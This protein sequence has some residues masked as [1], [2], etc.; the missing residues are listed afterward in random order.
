F[1]V[2]STSSQSERDFSSDYNSTSDSDDQSESEN[3]DDAQSDLSVNTLA[4]TSISLRDNRQT[5]TS[6]SGSLR[7]RAIDQ[8]HDSGDQRERSHSSHST[9]GQTDTLISD[10]IADDCQPASLNQKSTGQQIDA[11]N[12]A[13]IDDDSFVLE[14][15]IDTA[16]PVE[17]SEPSLTEQ[18]FLP[19]DNSLATTDSLWQPESDGDNY[20]AS[21]DSSINTFAI[22]PSSLLHQ[23]EPETNGSRRLPTSTVDQSYNSGDQRELPNLSL[24]HGAGDQT[25][26]LPSGTTEDNG[27][28]ANQTQLSSGQQAT[29]HDLTHFDDDSLPLEEDAN[30]RA[31]SLE[32]RE[33]SP[34]LEK[35]SAERQQSDISEDF[36]LPE[37]FEEP[38]INDDRDEEKLS[39]DEEL[40]VSSSGLPS[41]VVQTAPTTQTSLSIAPLDDTA[42]ETYRKAENDDLQTEK[43]RTVKRE[44]KVS[45]QT[46]LPLYKTPV[47]LRLGSSS[48]RADDSELT[49]KF[50]NKIASGKNKS[51]TAKKAEPESITRKAIPLSDAS[52][53]KGA[54]KSSAARLNQQLMLQK[55]PDETAISDIVEKEAKVDFQSTDTRTLSAPDQ[56]TGKRVPA[57]VSD[58]PTVLSE[59]SVTESRTPTALV[60]ASERQVAPIGHNINGLSPL[61]DGKALYFNIQATDIGSRLQL[62]LTP[63]TLGH[64]SIEQPAFFLKIEE[65]LIP[66]ATS[67]HSSSALAVPARTH[68]HLK[69]TILINW[70][71]PSSS[72]AITISRQVTL[73]VF[74]MLNAQLHKSG[75]CDLTID[76]NQLSALHLEK[77][78]A[79]EGISVPEI[80]HNR[81]ISALNHLNG[82]QEQ[83][84]IKTE[85]FHL[86]VEGDI[87]QATGDCHVGSS[88]EQEIAD[89]SILQIYPSNEASRVDRHT[90]K[91]FTDDANLAPIYWYKWMKNTTDKG[92]EDIR[93]SVRD[94]SRILRSY[95][96]KGAQ[97]AIH[98][99]ANYW[100]TP[101]EAMTEVAVLKDTTIAE[102]P[103]AFTPFTS[104]RAESEDISASHP[105]SLVPHS[106]AETLKEDQ[107]N[108]ATIGTEIKEASI[109]NEGSEIHLEDTPPIKTKVYVNESDSDQISDAGHSALL[110]ISLPRG[111]KQKK[112]RLQKIIPPQLRK[113]PKIELAIARAYDTSICY[114]LALCADKETKRKDIK[115]YDRDNNIKIDFIRRMLVDE[116]SFVRACDP[117]NVI[118]DINADI[119]EEAKAEK[120]FRYSILAKAEVTDKSLRGEAFRD[121]T[122]PVSAQAYWNFMARCQDDHSNTLD[123]ESEPNKG[124][125]KYS[126]HLIHK[127]ACFNNEFG[128]IEH[129]FN[130]FIFKKELSM[131]DQKRLRS[132]LKRAGTLQKH[133]E[134]CYQE[135][136]KYDLVQKTIENILSKPVGSD[137]QNRQ[138]KKLQ[139]I[140]EGICGKLNE[141][142]QSDAPEVQQEVVVSDNEPLGITTSPLCPDL[143]SE[144]THLADAHDIGL[145]DADRD[146]RSEVDDVISCTSDM[147]FDLSSDD[148]L[149]SEDENDPEK[150][151]DSL[152]DD[153]KLNLIK[154]QD[155]M[156][157]QHL[158]LTD[159]D[160]LALSSAE[161]PSATCMSSLYTD[162]QKVLDEI[163][164]Q[165][166]LRTN[167]NE[168]ITDV[169]RYISAIQELFPVKTFSL[170]APPADDVRNKMYSQLVDLGARYLILTTQPEASSRRTNYGKEELGISAEFLWQ[171]QKAWKSASPDLINGQVAAMLAI[172]LMKP[173]QKIFVFEVCLN[174]QIISLEDIRRNIEQLKNKQDELSDRLKNTVSESNDQMK[175]NERLLDIQGK[176]TT[177]EAQYT[178]L[179]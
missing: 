76:K 82:Q 128:Q 71:N 63:E 160:K 110:T 55:Q 57:P 171:T 168:L 43:K 86:K 38:L 10:T 172:G 24:S 3:N 32:I 154:N 166:K 50:L 17:S 4:T 115:P 136:E 2:S 116:Q 45:P 80:T 37:T 156:E 105:A 93:F 77:L 8:L 78:F 132:L 25:D 88:L 13:Q 40:S 89:V 85:I 124:V 75:T 152:T 112:S 153:Q 39:A 120:R 133:A 35:A 176:L 125:L 20:D 34:V 104:I 94:T 48:R 107:N 36:G 139:K 169:S 174:T 114:R 117:Y 66:P 69:V 52:L 72:T 1:D 170:Q 113:R 109:N 129:D 21:Q 18:S 140:Q 103:E 62:R 149:L 147:S 123:E 59:K 122:R 143:Q 118:R 81:V 159:D 12:L 47:S 90:K 9:D 84:G 27:H 96:I 64:S 5:A 151:P 61:A 28:L 141:K 155:S 41:R 144:N 130:Q 177:F 42:P 79:L 87:V 26:I 23:E 108:E 135:C 16:L 148:H 165:G 22:T 158:F 138:C 33:P 178:D 54:H 56:Q 175:L 162:A 67:E 44:I 19:D 68:R 131:D 100:F 7:V 150:Q 60:R 70:D 173:E 30:S 14:E 31:P 73:E 167:A 102:Q 83:T 74:A 163:Y 29:I 146:I 91:F 99:A 145:N 15:D 126:F 111:R 119:E 97:W 11:H 46:E 98:S 95:P 161:M 179:R 157:L 127:L 164:V 6:D 92:M 101:S 137:S 106:S 49:K 121:A 53:Q 65:D 134:S 51:P 142:P 58:S